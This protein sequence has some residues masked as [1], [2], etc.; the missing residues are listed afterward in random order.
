MMN[1]KSLFS[2]LMLML[3]FFACGVEPSQT[4]EETTEEK[5]KSKLDKYVNVRLTTDLEKLSDNHKKMIPIL[6][7][8]GKIMDDLFWY[9]AYGDK[10]ALLSSIKDEED[11]QFARINYGP[12]DRLDGN[13]PFIEGVGPKP[14]GANFYPKDMTKEEFETSELKD[15]ASLYTFI[16]RDDNGNLISVPYREQFAEQVAKASDLLK[17]AAELAENEGLKKYL[18]MRAEALLTDDYQPS[19]LAWMDM[20]TN[21]LDVVIG[22]IET[23]EDQ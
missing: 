21:V 22:P 17:Q 9:E 13:A 8:A 19:Y 18:T 4:T 20:K 6:I 7:E 5:P 11:R 15:K 23:Y 3:L 16:R 12:W 10:A 1:K 14:A 2:I